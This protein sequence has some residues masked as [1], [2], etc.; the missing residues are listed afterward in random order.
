MA[1]AFQRNDV[2]GLV[3]FASFGT[4]VATSLPVAPR[5]DAGSR[6]E[7]R[8]PAERQAEARIEEMKKESGE[9]MRPM[10][11][12]KAYFLDSAS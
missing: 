12:L 9:E 6:K 3:A 8:S 5:S 11:A 4:A 7:G 2:A 1:S 10:R